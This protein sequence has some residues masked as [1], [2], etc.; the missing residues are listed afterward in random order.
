MR[1]VFQIFLQLNASDGN[2]ILLLDM[3]SITNYFKIMCNNAIVHDNVSGAFGFNMDFLT[4][5]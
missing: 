1:S 5:Q 4:T 3:F 2:F